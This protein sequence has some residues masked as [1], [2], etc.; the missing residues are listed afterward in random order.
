MTAIEAKGSSI[1]ANLAVAA[2]AVFLV[3][4]TGQPAG[5]KVSPDALA[6]VERLPAAQR[7]LVQALLHGGQEHVF[8]GWTG[9]AGANDPLLQQLVELD[10]AYTGGLAAYLTSARDLLDKAA[11]GANA[12]RG[13][14]PAVPHGHD[15]QLGTPGFDD[16]ESRGLLLARRTAYV[17]VAGGL[18]ERLGYSGIKLELPTD[19]LTRRSF[20]QLYVESILALE[21]EAGRAG[22]DGPGA[23]LAIMVSGDT[24]A[25]TRALL[26]ENAFFGMEPARVHV[27]RQEKVAALADVRARLARG[28]R[29][30]AFFQDTNAL[31]FRSLTAAV[32]TSVRHGLAMNSV[33]VSRKAGEAVGALM[34]LSRTRGSG[35]AREAV[36]VNVEYNQ[37]DALLREA[38]QGGD[39]DDAATGFSP[40]P[41]SINQIVVDAGAYARVLAATGGAVPEFV[42]PKWA[43][44]RGSAL[45]KP[46]RLECMMQD[47]AWK[48]DSAADKV[49][50]TRFA[51]ASH[52]FAPVKNSVEGAQ[53]KL[54]AGLPPHSAA[55]GE[56]ALYAANCAL[57]RAAG[58]DVA[59]A[60]TTQ[61]AGITLQQPPLVTFSPDFAPT[62]AALRRRLPK[63]NRV[64]LG[65][66]ASLVVEGGGVVIE[67][68][69]LRGALHI[70]A[71]E[72]GAHVTVRF[73]QPVDNEGHTLVPLSD[74][75][76]AEAQRLAAAGLG[77]LGAK[78]VEQ[79]RMRGYRL[80]EQPGVTK[81]VYV[82]PKGKF[83]LDE[84]GLRRCK[85]C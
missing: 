61:H 70:D 32:G 6:A 22:A 29:Y 28:L 64:S 60:A 63:P 11:R 66:R 52:V 59:P 12:L 17:L 46:T 47:I 48:F 80:E 19:L 10:G 7:K 75:D 56:L 65:A 33:C 62:A 74:D 50:F 9:A 23:E 78:G 68:L 15:L 27:L 84:R 40:Y 16:A 57:L 51:D 38:G 1:V 44:G 4:S 35:S 58:A 53:A 39:A 5:P 41:G 49:G 43:A 14:A 36:T 82:V 8:E 21:S 37:V 20:L 85:L 3:Y 79:L 30:V 73:N 26:R 31:A 81:H 55:S 72:P 24:D 42:N 34:A 71:Q 77:E 2:L 69:R 67:S 18:G 25:A 54:R 76:A 45:K 83:T 13:F